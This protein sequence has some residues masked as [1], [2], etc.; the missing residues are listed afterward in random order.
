[1]DQANSHIPQKHSFKFHGDSTEYFGIWIV[2]ILLSCITLGIYSAWAKVR[3][4]QYFYGNTELDGDRFEY[5][6]KPLQILLGRII[7]AIVFAIWISTSTLFPLVNAGLGVLLMLVFPFLATRNIRFDAR[8]TRFRNV[9]FDFQGSYGGA[10][11]AFLGKP[12]IAY[13]L[14]LIGLMLSMAAIE[15][16]SILAICAALIGLVAVIILTYSW[17]T[18]GVARYIVNGYRYG[19]TQ[20]K[21]KVDTGE[22][23]EIVA[24]AALIVAAFVATF[25]A[26]TLGASDFQPSFRLIRDNSEAQLA[27]SV[28]F[29]VFF[30]FLY[31]SIFIFGTIVYGFIKAKTRNYL[32]NQIAIDDNLRLSSNIPVSGFIGLMLTNAL[33]TIFTLGL[34][35]P[36]V[37]IRTATYLAEYTH[38][39]GDM[40]FAHIQ[41]HNAGTDNAIADE[42]VDIFDLNIGAI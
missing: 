6:A 2:N 39:S 21:A 30:V 24:W 22:Y 29:I 7:A 8:M 3:T 23:M 16:K 11:I 14:L 12:V 27:K 33:I 17:V 31:F 37:D 4:N 19:E 9:R 36:W 35:R 13:V 40:G 26:L 25:L 20:F 1:M 5:L 15:S 10:Y 18:A 34:G 42:M 32:F 38:A 41:D 28:L